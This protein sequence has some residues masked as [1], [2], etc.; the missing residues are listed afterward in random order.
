MPSVVHVVQTLTERLV[1]ALLIVG[2]TLQCVVPA[3]AAATPSA[4]AAALGG[5]EADR[6]KTG[7][8]QGREGESLP[9]TTPPTVVTAG[10]SLG[11]ES[12][13]RRSNVQSLWSELKAFF[14]DNPGWE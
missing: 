5:I 4:A 11:T 3:V 7:T 10:G 2:L 14:K 13:I 1:S 8:S 12:M 9:Q 6:A